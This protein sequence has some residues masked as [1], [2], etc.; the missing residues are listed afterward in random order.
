MYIHT[1]AHLPTQ[2]LTFSHM[3]HAFHKYKCVSFLSH[4]HEHGDF[5]VM[6][7]VELGY[8]R[9]SVDKDWMNEWMNVLRP[10]S[11]SPSSRHL[12][13]IIIPKSH[14]QTLL[15]YT[16]GQGQPTSLSSRGRHALPWS[17]R[18][19]EGHLP[20]ADNVYGLVQVIPLS[21]RM[22]A[23]WWRAFPG[24]GCALRTLCMPHNKQTVTGSDVWTAFRTYHHSLV[25]GTWQ[26]A[27]SSI[28]C[29]LPAY[30]SSICI[31]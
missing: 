12:T 6:F 23:S 2:E 10:A 31:S 7:T 1:Y 5:N 11:F 22:Y 24:L 25:P 15:P 20:I 21:L 14:S 16:L 30:H 26:S 18:F 29:H 8:G 17:Y 4:K 9:D 27:L 3:P 28:D 19:Q 13:I